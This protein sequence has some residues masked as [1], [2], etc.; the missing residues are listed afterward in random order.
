LSAFNISSRA[1]YFKKIFLPHYFIY[2][3]CGVQYQQ[4][5]FIKI[6]PFINVNLLKRINIRNSYKLTVKNLNKRIVRKKLY[7]RKFQYK[8]KLYD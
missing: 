2:K 8:I 6:K 1:L 7:L 4:N 5:N 3:I